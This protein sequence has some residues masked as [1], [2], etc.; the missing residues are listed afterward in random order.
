MIYHGDR[1][2]IGGVLCLDFVNTVGNRLG[3]PRQYIT[4]YRDL[5]SWAVHAEALDEQAAS[6]LLDE[7]AWRAGEAE[8][9]T[10]RA[11][12]LRE[13]I[14]GLLDAAIKQGRP[15]EAAL[16]LLNAELASAT[17]QARLCWEESPGCFKLEWPAPAA[18]LDG[19]VRL[20]ARS[21]AELLSDERLQR[22]RRCA[23][24]SC[25]WLFL[26]TSK[27][28]SRRWCSMDDC[29]NRAKARRHYS[30]VKAR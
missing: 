29:G 27:N 17:R 5:L 30:R 3:E 6:V 2:L 4:S 23:N 10:Q 16:V 26:D 13:A 11:L 7:A 19:I 22:V 21:A 14:F 1:S 28:Q 18:S 15:D 24:P 12:A 8:Q 25:G 9:I 20:I